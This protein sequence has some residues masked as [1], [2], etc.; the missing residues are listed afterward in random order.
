M[1]DRGVPV[2]PLRRLIATGYRQ[3]SLVQV[4]YGGYGQ[5]IAIVRRRLTAPAGL[6]FARLL[7]RIVSRMMRSTVLTH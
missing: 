7:H 1:G 6:R 5:E 3:G 4:D 2:P